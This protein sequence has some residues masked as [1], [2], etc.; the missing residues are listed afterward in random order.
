MRSQDFCWLRQACLV[1][2]LAICQTT[3]R[4]DRVL[5]ALSSV[6]AS[7]SGAGVIILFRMKKGDTSPELEPLL[8]NGKRIY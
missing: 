4:D 6:L 7:W 5:R 8:G 3:L 1:K 2:G